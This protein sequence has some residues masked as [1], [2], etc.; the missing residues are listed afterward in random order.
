MAV[1]GTRARARSRHELFVHNVFL[2]ATASAAASVRAPL[3]VVFVLVFVDVFRLLR[4][5][6]LVR[7]LVVQGGFARLVAV[8]VLVL[9]L[10]ARLL[11]AR[12]LRVAR[13]L[14]VLRRLLAG[15][16]RG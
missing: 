14:L 7:A 2:F 15:E 6:Q 10:W 11:V 3:L 1:A 5:V 13:L 9:L 16:R 8:M 4:L 12:L